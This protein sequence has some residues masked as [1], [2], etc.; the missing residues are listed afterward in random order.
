MKNLKS[1]F[2]IIAIAIASFTNASAAQ[3]PQFQ[4]SIEEYIKNPNLFDLDL[5]GQA[6]DYLKANLIAYQQDTSPQGLKVYGY[7]SKI[8]KYD[9]TNPLQ[10]Q[11]LKQVSKLYKYGINPNSGGAFVDNWSDANSYYNNVGAALNLLLPYL[12][13]INF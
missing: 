11:L 2:A 9:G 1:I 13:S 7:V 6:Q 10:D 5:V 4:H 12:A 3:P 8:L